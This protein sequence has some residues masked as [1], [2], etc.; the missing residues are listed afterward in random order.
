MCRSIVDTMDLLCDGF[1]SLVGHAVM[2]GGAEPS[3]DAAV[4]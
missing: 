2:G 4:G 1:G 3:D